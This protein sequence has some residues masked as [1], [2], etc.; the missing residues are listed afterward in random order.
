MK[1]FVDGIVS[2]FVSEVYLVVSYFGGDIVLVCVWFVYLILY[3]IFVYVD[4]I[5]YCV[6]WVIG[7]FDKLDV[8]I[9]IKNIVKLIFKSKNNFFI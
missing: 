6:S 9:C 1:G 3:V 8:K 5:L 2:Y 4:F 7:S